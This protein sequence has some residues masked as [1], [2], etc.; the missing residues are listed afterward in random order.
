MRFCKYS[1]AGNLFTVLDGRGESVEEMRTPSGIGLLCD[2]F[3]T[4]G[5]IIITDSE[6]ED[7]KM[8]FYNPDGTSGMMCGNGGR[9]AVSF[10]AA[11]GIKPSG[12]DGTYSFEAPDGVHTARI[13]STE[14]PMDMVCLSMRDV[15]GTTYMEE[16]EEA[17][18]DGWK[19][20]TGARHFVVFDEDVEEINV[21]GAGSVIRSCKEFAPEGTNVD[22]VC[23]Y[24]GGIKVR[25][26]EKGVEGETLACGTG[27]VAAAIASFRQGVAPTSNE[28][29][30]ITYKVKARIASLSVSFRSD[31]DTFTG[32]TLTGPA[33]FVMCTY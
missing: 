31:G 24:A 12:E 20:D 2:E 4:E 26:F 9:V 25:T 3:S 5:V 10:A 8:E 33:T 16:L 7:F 23:P 14:G 11:L 18:V 13:L 21:S 15:T 17:P 19:L 6:T 22:F 30:L 29:G 32:I 28:D 27:A 1:G